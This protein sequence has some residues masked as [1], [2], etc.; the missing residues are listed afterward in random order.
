LFPSHRGVDR[1]LIT[2]F[3]SGYR[4]L[5]LVPAFWESG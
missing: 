1:K 2:M 3:K 4:Y 5:L